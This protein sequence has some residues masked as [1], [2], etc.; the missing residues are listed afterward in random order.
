MPVH[1]YVLIYL[2]LRSGSALHCVQFVLY[3][4]RSC[5]LPRRWPHILAALQLNRTTKSRTQTWRRLT[6]QLKI[7][8]LH[9]REKN[10]FC[11]TIVRRRNRQINRKC[12][13]QCAETDNKLMKRNNRI[14]YFID[15]FADVVGRNGCANGFALKASQLFDLIDWLA[16][17]RLSCCL[18][19]CKRV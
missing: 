5:H 7:I 8:V 11:R 6:V 2:W 17:I 4:S 18:I 3:N 15:Q 10:E 16:S 13:K 1:M 14:Y 9:A 12:T 19:V